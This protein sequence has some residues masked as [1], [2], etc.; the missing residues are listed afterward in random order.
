MPL[1]FLAIL[2][3]A[4]G[5]IL[6]FFLLFKLISCVLSG[7]FPGT[8]LFLLAKFFVY[9]LLFSV[10][11]LWLRGVLACFGLA[12]GVS[13]LLSAAVFFLIRKRKENHPS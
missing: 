11:I 9:A 3:A 1:I 10:F 13:Y 7:D 6:Q 2:A 8:G 12:L 4:G 5:G